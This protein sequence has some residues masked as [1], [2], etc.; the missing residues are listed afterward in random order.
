MPGAIYVLVAAMAGSIVSRNR[1]ILLRTSVPLAVGLGAGWV[2]LP[3]TMRN[4]G[5]LV[6]RYEERFPVIADNHLRIRRAAQE[7]WR[8]TK[9]H[10]LG[11]ANAVDEK[12]QGGRDAAEE[13]VRKGR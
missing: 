1:N 3:I 12:I 5:D 6:W 7:G 10:G 9:V 4:I 8:Q 11:F 2:V 13:W